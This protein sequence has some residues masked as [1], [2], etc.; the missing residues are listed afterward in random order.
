MHWKV[1]RK[2]DDMDKPFDLM[3]EDTR[4]MIIKVLNESGLPITVMSMV[5]KELC[6]DIQ[7]QEA[8][9]IQKQRIKYEEGKN[10]NQ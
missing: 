8:V 6:S 5:L 7:T 4:H 3:V 1:H 2:D 10:D 9:S